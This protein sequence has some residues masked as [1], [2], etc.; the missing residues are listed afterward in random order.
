MTKGRFFLLA[1][2]VAAVCASGFW[3]FSSLS[4]ADALAQQMSE[5]N[6]KKTALAE[7]KAEARSQAVEDVAMQASGLQATRIDEDATRISDMCRL[8]F[9]WSDGEQYR[10][11]RDKLSEDWGITEDSQLLSEFM[12]ALPF[13]TDETGNP[14]D[15][16]DKAALH[17][18]MENIETFVT[19][20]TS[21]NYKYYSIV[22]FS[23]TDSKGASASQE[24]GVSCTVA[25]DGSVSDIYACA[26]IG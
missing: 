26:L 4:E 21:E 7:A 14:V 1:L 13:L 2:C 15:T 22:T 8:V 10:A 12:T 16:I 19:D 9:S 23:T 18:S 5:A 11:N 24:V 6:E 20:T 25:P 17:A 3:F